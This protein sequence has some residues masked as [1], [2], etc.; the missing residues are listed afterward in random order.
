MPST[1]RSRFVPARLRRGFTTIELL[2]VLAIIAVLAG[3]TFPFA[4]SLFFK[5]DLSLSADQVNTALNRARTLALEGMRGDSWGY[6]VEHGVIFKGASYAMRE[7]AFDE[8]L[9]IVGG[10]AVSGIPEVT[11]R[12]IEGAPSATGSIIL[13][14]LQGDTVVVEILGSGIAYDPSDGVEVCTTDDAGQ[15]QTL[16]I[17]QSL[18][19]IHL[20]QGDTLGP[21]PTSEESSV[22]GG[23]SASGGGGSSGGGGGGGSS[24]V[25]YTSLLG[26]VLLSSSTPGSLTLSGNAR[27]TVSPGGGAQINSANAAAVKLSGNAVLTIP[28][29]NVGGTPGTS[30]S[31]NAVL[32]GT[33]L[34]GASPVPDPLASVPVPTP[35]ATPFPKATVNGNNVR[36]LDPGTYNGG[37]AVSGNAQVTL[38]PGVYYL[39]GGL[40]VSGNGRLTGS[41]V[42]IYCTDGVFKLSGNGIVSLSNRTVG[43]YAGVTFFQERTS[44]Q[45]VQITGNGNLDLHGIFYARDAGFTLSG[46]GTS[47]VVG[48]ALVGSSLTMS[49]NGAF[50]V[51]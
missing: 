49:G 12:H 14:N 40:S 38:N 27:L 8:S 48:T 16:L 11:F 36:T 32:N 21:C 37:I 22:S 33:V 29:L 18:L 31:G 34:N 46:N 44:T 24:S 43:P 15:P 4:R 51:Q 19:Q 13:T 6:S 23:S 1:P 25:P 5:N 47:D 7:P 2:V 41:D 3:L 39:D 17:A 28:T 50:T 30:V 26:M 42:M 20:A 9:G 35:S 10:V 45:N